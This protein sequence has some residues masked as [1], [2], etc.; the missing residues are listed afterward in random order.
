M[1]PH[2]E[3]EPG[4]KERYGVDVG[5]ALGREV[6]TTMKRVETREWVG[7]VAGCLDVEL[8]AHVHGR[9]RRAQGRARNWTFTLTPIGGGSRRRWIRAAMEAPGERSWIGK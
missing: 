7:F 2:G 9:D 6:W 3:G 8:D 4:H 5:Q 1:W